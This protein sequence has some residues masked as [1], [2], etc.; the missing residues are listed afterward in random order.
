MNRTV[1]VL[2]MS[3]VAVAAG[4]AFS[5]PAMAATSSTSSTS[6][7]VQSSPRHGWVEGHFRTSS[8][9]DRT[10][11]I[12]RFLGRWD[13]YSCDYVWRGRNRGSW[14]LTVSRGWHGGDWHGTGTG[15]GDWNHQHGGWDHQQGNHQQGGWDH[16][17]G[18]H[19]QGGWD[20]QQS[21]HQ[22][23]GWDHQQSNH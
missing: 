9:C 21:N 6:T 16:Q 7:T 8:Q 10:G 22:Q 1:R 3:G 2:L 18:N 13:H 5:A 14:E 17:Q 19:Q 23:G 20:H 12:G 15:N 11:R 4:M